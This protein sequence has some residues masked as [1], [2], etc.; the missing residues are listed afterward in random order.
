MWSGFPEPGSIFFE[1]D[2]LNQELA[3]RYGIVVSTSHHEPMQ[4]N[5]SEWRMSNKGKW[6]WEENKPN[7]AEF[8]RAG[9]ERAHPYESILTLG[10]RGESDGAIESGDPR[11]ILTDVIATQRNI[12]SDVYGRPD[13]V[14]RKFPKIQFPLRSTFSPLIILNRGHG[15]VQ[16][17]SAVL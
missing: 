1:D 14:R 13:G 6:V 9:A 3:H 11:A 15:F 4:R 10:M 7:I 8:M 17:G 2:P 16:R 5:M 12:I